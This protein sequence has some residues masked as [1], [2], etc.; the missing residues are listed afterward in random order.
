VK[1]KSKS[2]KSFITFKIDNIDF[3]EAD[4][5]IVDHTGYPSSMGRIEFREKGIW[6]SVSMTKMNDYAA[7]TICRMLKFS[8]GELV[9]KEQSDRVCEKLEGNNY[10]GPDL[11]PVHFTEMRCEKNQK[12]IMDCNRKVA[13][14][15]TVHIT[16]AVVKCLDDNSDL[17]PEPE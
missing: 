3:A 17:P 5:R 4:M 6:G 15:N 8:D 10:C 2:N 11:S 14:K 16:D 1:S 7:Q 12:N 13:S 9:K